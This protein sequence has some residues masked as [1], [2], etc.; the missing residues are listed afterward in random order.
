ME[1]LERIAIEREC[2]RLVTAYCHYV[3]HGEAAKIAEQFTDDGQWLSP[4]I[5]MIGKEKLRK[6]FAGRQ[7]NTARMSRHVCNNLLIDVIDE[8]NAEGVVYLTLYRFDG[9]AGRKFSPIDE[10]PTMVGE[11]RDKFVRTDEGWRFSE[12]VID[13]SFIGSKPEDKDG[14]ETNG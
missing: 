9:E 11:Y 4:E 5:K 7:A 12:R 10:Q 8:D 14:G 6:G 2:Q 3:D 13:I 1:M